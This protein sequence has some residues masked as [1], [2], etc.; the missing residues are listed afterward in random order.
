MNTESNKTTIQRAQEATNRGPICGLHVC[1]CSND[2]TEAQEAKNRGPNS[3]GKLRAHSDYTCVE[4]LDQANKSGMLACYVCIHIIGAY[5]HLPPLSHYLSPSL[6]PSLSLSLSLSLPRSR[7]QQI[8]L[9]C[10][11]AAFD[12][13]SPASA[14]ATAN[15]SSLS[16]MR[17]SV[18]KC[19]L[20]SMKHNVVT[21]YER[22]TCDMCAQSSYTHTHACKVCMHCMYA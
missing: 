15:A 1:Q 16:P 3:L 9:C 2:N 7:V 17:C 5:T 19:L 14:I 13:N 10:A 6:S 11:N 12:A 8:C 20:E 4:L 18:M 21:Q 22:C